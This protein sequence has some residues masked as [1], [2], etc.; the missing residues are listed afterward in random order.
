MK[1]ALALSF[2]VGFGLSA[3]LPVGASDVPPEPAAQTAAQASARG[4][5]RQTAGNG[6]FRLAK[7]EAFWVVRALIA[8]R[9]RALIAGDAGALASLTTA[10][11]SA[12][13]CDRAVF[14]RY[15]GKVATLRTK[16]L[17]VEAV[18]ARTW[19]VR[20]V[21]EEF[22]TT[23]G[24]SAGPRS[25]RCSLWKVADSPWR[26]RDVAECSAATAPAKG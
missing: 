15:G 12:R 7:G 25:P 20:T 5:V 26:L 16:L 6:A 3:A 10:E 24:R 23:D 18:D 17:G 4:A 13:R 1:R 22:A 9:D 8:R 11:G 14:R 21:Q 19:R 2:G